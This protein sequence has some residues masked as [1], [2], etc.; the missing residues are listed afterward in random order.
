MT[1]T[2]RTP[3]SKAH[4]PILAIYCSDGRYTRAVEEL[5]ESLGHDRIDVLCV[6]GGPGAMDAW[7]CGSLILADHLVRQAEFLIAG[8]G[9][10]EVILVSHEGCGFY[11][12]QHALLDDAGRGE[13]QAK[14]LRSVAAALRRRH[15]NVRVH[16]FHA[17]HDGS[18]IVFEAEPS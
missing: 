12:Q 15:P 2:A 11:K 1:V 9:T 3:F 7:T 4:P 6:P 14:D 16:T 8:H 10:T 18:R 13:R 5:A 17:G